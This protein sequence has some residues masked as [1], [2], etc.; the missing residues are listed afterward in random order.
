MCNLF[1]IH[2][3][4]NYFDNFLSFILLSSQSYI[5]F[6]TA[7]WS[8]KIL[9]FKASKQEKYKWYA[10]IYCARVDKKLKSAS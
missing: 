3:P 9:F 4:S 8:D 2:V 6:I 7:N 1:Y 10:L 5:L